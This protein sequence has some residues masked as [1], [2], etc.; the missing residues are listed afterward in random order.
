MLNV[1]PIIAVVGGILL[2]IALVRTFRWRRYNAIHREY[3]PKW[4]NGKGNI[5][6]EEAQ[7]IMAVSAMYDI[8]FWSNFALAFV[9]LKS[10]GIVP[11]SFF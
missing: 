2:W 3:G 5:T 6:P 8:P 1:P 11:T 7:K 10:Y 9:L 4:N